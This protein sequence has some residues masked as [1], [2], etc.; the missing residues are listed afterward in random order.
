MLLCCAL[1]ILSYFTLTSSNSFHCAS[2]PET[3]PFS[4]LPKW[5]R[6]SFW[7]FIVLGIYIL[8]SLTK[9]L[10]SSVLVQL[11]IWHSGRRY[12]DLCVAYA[13]WC[14]ENFYF[15][16]L[17]CTYLLVFWM[18]MTVKNYVRKRQEIHSFKNGEFEINSMFLELQKLKKLFNLLDWNL[19]QHFV[20]DIDN[21]IHIFFSLF[22]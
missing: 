4:Y 5:L 7:V 8:S 1:S 9:P 12:W 14:L 10:W 15:S 6:S 16:L 13:R 2:L 17:H 22:F 20:W 11:S 21:F 18:D 19:L 3:S